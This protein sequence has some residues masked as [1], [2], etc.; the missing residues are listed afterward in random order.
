MPATRAHIEATTRYEAKAYDKI[1]LRIRKDGNFTREH[2]QIAADRAAKSIN[3]YILEAVQEKIY[4]D[5]QKS[6]DKK[7]QNDL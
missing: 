5:N 3:S 7:P 6:G 2:I 4:R 1:L